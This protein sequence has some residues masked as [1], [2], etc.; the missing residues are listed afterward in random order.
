MER[1]LPITILMSDIDGL[2]LANDALGHA[3]GDELIK[4]ASAAITKGCRADDIIA[5][6]G[7][8]EFQVI[9]PRTDSLAAEKVIQR[10]KEFVLL[11]KVGPLRVSV[12]FGSATK[13]NKKQN[14]HEIIKIAEDEMYRYK[15]HEKRGLRRKSIDAIMNDMYERNLDGRKPCEKGS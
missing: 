15:L 12:S 10:I 6:T 4:K 8:D 5:R 1:N 3:V 13:I 9:L 14:I 11:D 7:G 2:K